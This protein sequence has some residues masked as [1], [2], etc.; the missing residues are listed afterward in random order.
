GPPAGT[1]NILGMQWSETVGA[2]TTPFAVSYRLRP[3]ASGSNYELVRYFCSGGTVRSDVVAHSL[4]GPAFQP[5][6]PAPTGQTITMTLVAVPPS[7]NS[8]AGNYSF[9]FS[10]NMR[11]PVPPPAYPSVLSINRLGATPTNAG[12]GQLQWRVTFDRN[13]TGVD[14]TDFVTEVTNLSGVGAPTVSGSSGSSVY[15]VS[16]TVPSG[17]TSG[18]VG[19]D[20]VDNDSIKDASANLLGGPGT[21]ATFTGQ[22]YEIDRTPPSATIALAAASPTSGP[23]L[24]WT[25]TF[26]SD[27]TGVD[28]GDFTLAASGVTTGTTTLTWVSPTQYT[29]T[30]G[31][32]YGTGTL[33]LN[34]VDNNSIID[35]AGNPL[36]SATGAADGSVTG[37]VY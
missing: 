10:G 7:A 36:G 8:P 34:L 24:S 22:S 25:V 19:L 23:N 3:A 4:A 29:V 2:T 20:L 9:T 33:G 35:A 26:T 16:V 30:N 18:A 21:G 28:A 14:P 27:V 15:T 32:V 13:V 17:T 5:T 11:T 37:P 12:S 1:T 6:V 31:P